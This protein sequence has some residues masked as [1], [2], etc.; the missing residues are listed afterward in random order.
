MTSNKYWRFDI[1]NQS[2][3]TGSSGPTTGAQ[4]SDQSNPQSFVVIQASDQQTAL[5]NAKQILS[6]SYSNSLQTPTE[7]SA[8]EAKTYQSTSQSSMT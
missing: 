7:I 5:Q 1:P 4:S 3:T 8:Q 2:T 6:S